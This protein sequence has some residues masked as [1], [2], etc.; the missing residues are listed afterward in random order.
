LA[1]LKVASSKYHVL[2]ITNLN[3]YKSIQHCTVGAQCALTASCRGSSQ[4][5]PISS[6]LKAQDQQDA[7]GER[8]RW[9]A[10]MG[11]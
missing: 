6:A 10:Q 2:Y 11:Q 1:R 7:T 8:T 4:L 3:V 9:M 5:A